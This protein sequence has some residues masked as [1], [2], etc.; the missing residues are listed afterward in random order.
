MVVGGK[1]SQ[2]WRVFEEAVLANI[3]RTMACRIG[4]TGCV[5]GALSRAYQLA[6]IRIVRHHAEHDIPILDS[7]L[8]K[9][10]WMQ[11]SEWGVV[12][13]MR[14][15]TVLHLCVL[16]LQVVAR[17]EIVGMDSGYSRKPWIESADTCR[18]RPSS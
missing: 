13:D 7:G 6:A 12:D 11:L 16:L 18:Q 9:R 5:A 3:S 10:I 4:G 14:T 15:D 2:L 17:E 8:P 1:V